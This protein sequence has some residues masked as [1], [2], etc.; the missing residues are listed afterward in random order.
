[1]KDFYLRRAQ[2]WRGVAM[3]GGRV[4]D[5]SVRRGFCW[6]TRPTMTRR[7]PASFSWPKTS[8]T[9][10][11]MHATSHLGCGK[12]VNGIFF[13]FLIMQAVIGVVAYRSEMG[14]DEQLCHAKSWA[15]A[16]KCSSRHFPSQTQQLKPFHPTSF[17][18]CRHLGRK[19]QR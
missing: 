2:V 3:N 5:V 8:S 9:N 12:L 1:M 14:R 11:P 16:H 4:A 13:S 7:T 15:Q 19:K 17:L 10:K 6:C 18:C